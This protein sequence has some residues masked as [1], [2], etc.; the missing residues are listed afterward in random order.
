MNKGHWKSYLVAL[1]LAALLL[2]AAC[3]PT[4]TPTPGPTPPPPLET[5][6]YTDSEHGFSVEYPKD[7]EIQAGFM[8]TI[9]TFTGPVEEETGGAINVNIGATTPAEPPEVTLEEYVRLFQL[10]VEED[11]KNYEKVDEYDAVVDDLAAIVWTWKEDFAGTTLTVTMAFFMKED[12]VYGIS[13]GATSEVYGDYLGCFELV[14]DS[15]KFD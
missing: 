1:G 11:A 10:G 9:V 14:L 13:Y 8:G 12:V 4:T 15:F 3:A 2:V 5:L 7:W 6:T